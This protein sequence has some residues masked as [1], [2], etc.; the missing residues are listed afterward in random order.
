METQTASTQIVKPQNQEL[1]SMSATPDGDSLFVEKGPHEADAQSA[2]PVEALP[3]DMGHFVEQCAAA[4]PVAPEMVGVPALVVAGAAIGNTRAVRLKEGW[5]ESNALWAAIVSLSG[6]KKSP[7]LQKAVEPLLSRETEERRTWTNDV[8]VERLGAL[9]AASPR[10]LFSYRDELS[11]W[12]KS[13]NQYR[14]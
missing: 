8:T 4:L 12:V 14:G 5:T 1:P 7:A 3:P 2:F 13:M 11:A 10:G 6:T 9:L